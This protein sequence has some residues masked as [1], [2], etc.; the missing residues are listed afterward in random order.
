M[1]ATQPVPWTTGTFGGT[2]IVQGGLT[3]GRVD[4]I[5]G[6]NY[7]LVGT[8]TQSP[9]P[10]NSRSW[11]TRWPTRS[12]RAAA[13]EFPTLN[14]SIPYQFISDMIVE[15]NTV[16]VTTAG[17]SF[18][19]GFEFDDQ[20]GTVLSI[21]VSNPAAPR[22]VGCALQQPG[23]VGWGRYHPVRGGDRQQ[24]DR[25]H[26]QL[27]KHGRQHAGRR[28]AGLGGRLLEPGCP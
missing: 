18:F 25:V 19:F 4:N 28:G 2:S 13:I 27:H 6:T 22:L 15:G 3:V 14:G 21:D 16:L 11:F 1:S 26:R 8:T 23:P 5:G 7:L 9:T 12:A 17:Y 20:F 24:P 10:A